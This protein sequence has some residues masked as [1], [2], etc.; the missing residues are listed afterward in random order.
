MIIDQ[1]KIVHKITQIPVFKTRKQQKHNYMDNKYLYIND[2][3]IYFIISKLKI[4]VNV[5]V[6]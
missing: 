1:I 4:N 5:Y 3:I 6:C 2:Y